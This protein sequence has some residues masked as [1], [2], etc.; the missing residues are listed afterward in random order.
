M[1]M[2]GLITRPIV[3]NLTRCASLVV[4]VF[5]LLSFYF[6]SLAD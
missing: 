1:K 5:D 6:S 2:A 4:A 3:I